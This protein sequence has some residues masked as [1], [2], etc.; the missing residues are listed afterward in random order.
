MLLP[1]QVRPPLPCPLTPVPPPC[2]VIFGPVSP[3]QQS[4]SLKRIEQI[5]EENC[6]QFKL[7]K[8]D[9][10]CRLEA[11]VAWQA[12]FSTEFIHGSKS[13]TM[14]FNFHPFRNPSKFSRTKRQKKSSEQTVRSGRHCPF[15]PVLSLSRSELAEKEVPPGALTLVPPGTQ[16]SRMLGQPEPQ[17]N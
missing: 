6:W 17:L 14:R 4:P 13:A 10:T 12:L 15:L 9:V 11:H 5:C 8:L 16:V 3:K 2:V 1:S 7:H